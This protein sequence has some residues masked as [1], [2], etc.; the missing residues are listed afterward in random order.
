MVSDENVEKSMSLQQVILCWTLMASQGAR[1]L[2]ESITLKKPSES[3][4][5]FVHWILGL[6]YYIM[7]G[8]AIWVEGIGIDE[9]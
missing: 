3:K 4:M 1:R 6:V 8:I 2:Y 7:M 9:I 5:W